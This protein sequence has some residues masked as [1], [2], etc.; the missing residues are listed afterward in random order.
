MFGLPKLKIRQLKLVTCVFT[1][2]SLVAILLGLQA[3]SQV[4]FANSSIYYVSTTGSDSNDGRTQATP[5][6]TLA[7]VNSLNLGQ[8]DEVLFK[9]GDTW[10]GEV[11]EISKSG[12]QGMP[13]R[14]GSYPDSN[15]TAKPVISG[16]KAISGWANHSG[17]IFVAD[18]NT[19]SNTGNFPNGINQLFKNESRLQFA[20][21]PNLDAG[22]SGYSIIDSQPA[23]NQI[24]DNQ[25]P[26]G[27][28]NSARAHIRSMT[29]FISNREV[30]SVNNKT[31]N[32]N[33]AVDCYGTISSPSNCGNNGG[34]GY[35]L[36][37]S[38]SA[39]DQD[40]EWFW[41]RS[42]NKVYLQSN[43]GT[44]SNIEG[45]IILDTGTDPLGG[46]LLGKKDFPQ[47]EIK[48]VDFINFE[49]KNWYRN[50]ITTPINHRFC[51][52]QHLNILNNSIKNSAQDGIRFMSFIYD[53]TNT[54]AGGC[55][56]NGWVGGNEIVI[57]NNLIDGSNSH[58]IQTVAHDS[59]ITQNTI[60]NT[61]LYKN[62]GIDGLGG[63]I[64][65]GEGQYSEKGAA[66]NI[67][68]LGSGNGSNNTVT[69][70]TIKDSGYTGIYVFGENNR[71]EKNF[72]KNLGLTKAEAVG[73]RLYGTG[74]RNNTINLNIMDTISGNVDGTNDQWDYTIPR[75]GWGWGIHADVGAIATISNNTIRDT[76]AY[77]LLCD[78]N[79][80]G[81]CEMS[82]NTVFNAGRAG[83]G[84]SDGYTIDFRDNVIVQN[85]SNLVGFNQYEVNSPDRLTLNSNNNYLFSP[86]QTQDFMY[87]TGEKTFSQ[88]KTDSGRDT[89][90]KPAFYTQAEGETP[91]AQLFYN[92]T[93][94]V[95]QL[96]LP[97]NHKDKDQNT[98]SFPLNLQPFSSVVL[99][100]D[101][102]TP[103]PTP[104]TV[105]SAT[106][107]SNC[108]VSGSVNIGTAYN[109]DFA[110]SG[111][112]N[113]NYSL[114]ANGIKASTQTATGESLLCTIQNNQTSNAKLNCISI[115]TTGGT[116]GT[117]NILVNINQTTG[118]DKGDVNLVS[119]TPNPN[120]IPKPTLTLSPQSPNDEE[121][122]TLTASFTAPSS[123]ITKVEFYNGTNKLGESSTSPFQL[124]LN[125][126]FP[127]TYNF[128]AKAFSSSG[129]STSDVLTGNIGLDFK[130]WNTDSDGDTKIGPS[131]VIFQNKICQSHVG[132][133]R[134]IYTRCS[135]D[136]SNWSLWRRNS[137]SE[138][139]NK[140]V[141]LA[142]FNSRL[143]QVHRGDDTKIYTRSSSDAV[144]WTTWSQN[145]NGGETDYAI[146]MTTF[147]GRLWQTHRG[148]DKKIYTRSSGDGQSWTNWIETGGEA[149][150]QIPLAIFK[151]KMY[152]THLGYNDKVYTRSS[153][154]GQS[155]SGWAE[156]GGV[157]S[158]AQAPMSMDSNS[159]RLHQ[160]YITLD[161]K[162]YTRVS[163]D[164]SR[165]SA[166]FLD[167]GDTKTPIANIAFQGKFYQYHTGLDNKMYLREKNIR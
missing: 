119:T 144:T 152:Q 166:W 162:I 68:N 1:T 154:D 85:G 10:Q 41:D 12:I 53:G 3:G 124:T 63:S 114:P 89:N 45:S 156:V 11:L 125:K 82:G 111:D 55:G 47:T 33:T 115:P 96:S 50:G 83:L 121:N 80:G 155:W 25:L 59:L 14:Y 128:T 139:T 158:N 44:P 74:S 116:A 120:P 161:N 151:G 4:V 29:W 36:D 43:S 99:F 79:P 56:T 160:T 147:G 48:Y 117:Q 23:T 6:K 140:P 137:N 148:M 78:G 95:S 107:L 149:R 163:D 132:L 92:N 102:T 143:W 94:S 35:W 150:D 51:E 15:C 129:N 7:K 72:F 130:N 159:D 32:L 97:G 67:R 66:I 106:N 98:V 38:L 31:L 28:W 52:N 84:S 104:P 61:G 135:S 90:S 2:L 77:G 17:N 126:V 69:L 165:W 39:V 87:G 27:N 13:I 71:I 16:S 145:G 142:S 22:L 8:G 40:G 93:N 9:C 58:G 49:V 131:L 88:W 5:F 100:S 123:Q 57:R 81:Q 133:D 21:W 42:N 105:I 62:L 70:N 101:T 146:S 64:T 54:G 60:T 127:N 26:S 20:R 34:W 138:S 103:N 122:L 37:N 157:V 75:G 46:V 141:F 108:T 76:S 118:V 167:E 91:K 24:T 153:G 110:L 18:L 112:S 164:S 86:Y 134:L 19:G 136:F 65:D 30:S 113:N 73:V 109:C